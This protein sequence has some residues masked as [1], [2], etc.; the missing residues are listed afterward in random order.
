MEEI[1][2]PIKRSS[3]GIMVTCIFLITTASM[4]DDSSESVFDGK[5]IETSLGQG[6]WHVAYFFDK[7][8]ETSDFSGYNFTFND[9]GAALA[10]KNTTTVNGSWSTENLSSGGVKLILDFGVTSPLDELNEDWK[11]LEYTDARIK[12]EHVSGGSGDTDSL[13]LEKN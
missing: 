9:D 6:G 2:G 10:T 1:I 4:C 5:Q 12:L 13:I 7:K 8:D 3:V 11:I